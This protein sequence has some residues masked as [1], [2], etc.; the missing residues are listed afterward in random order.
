MVKIVMDLKLDLKTFLV[1]GFG[2]IGDV[3]YYDNS[4]RIFFNKCA[5]KAPKITDSNEK[6]IPK[7]SEMY[8]I[9]NKITNNFFIF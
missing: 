7:I 3:G 8:S 1:N 9:I 5:P 2:Y 4:G 6:V